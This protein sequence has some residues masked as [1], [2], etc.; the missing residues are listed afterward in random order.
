MGTG[1][2]EL[3]AAHRDNKSLTIYMLVVLRSM[4]PADPDRKDFLHLNHA[5]QSREDPIVGVTRPNA[6]E[7]VGVTPQTQSRAQSGP[8]RIVKR[9]A[10]RAANAP[11]SARSGVPPTPTPTRDPAEMRQRR[12]QGYAGHQGDDSS[13]RAMAWYLCMDHRV[14][15]RPN[16]VSAP[17]RLVFS[18]F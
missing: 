10:L 18:I 5:S 7:S 13:S 3:F 15:H 17:W 16:H 4:T 8:T 1:E 9:A 12:D 14:K 11:A 6:L 2:T